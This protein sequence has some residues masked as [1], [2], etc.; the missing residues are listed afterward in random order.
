MIFVLPLAERIACGVKDT[1]CQE[2][3]PR[4][5]WDYAGQSQVLYERVLVQRCDIIINNGVLRDLFAADNSQRQCPRGHDLISLH[6]E[7]LS[8]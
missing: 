4:R 6:G 1:Y 2:V 8:T 5:L 3:E 7:R